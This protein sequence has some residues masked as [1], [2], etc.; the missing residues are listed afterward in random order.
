VLIKRFKSAPGFV[1]HRNVRKF[2]V[3]PTLRLGNF[4]IL[5]TWMRNHEVWAFIVAFR[6]C[7]TALQFLVLVITS[8]Q[9]TTDFCALSNVP[10][11][12]RHYTTLR[13]NIQLLPS[14]Y[15]HCRQFSKEANFP[16]NAKGDWKLRF[17]WMEWV[18][19]TKWC[20]RK[21]TWLGLSEW[22][23]YRASWLEYQFVQDFD[24]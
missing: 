20:G 4:R 3:Q 21:F 24:L 18:D 7:S 23:N 12:E 5:Y 10:N 9:V 17:R 2:M 15:T 1:A 6:L 8:V 13:R 19:C 16:F 22:L 14:S 11:Q